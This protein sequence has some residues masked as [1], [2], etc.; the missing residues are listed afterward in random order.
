MVN[1][2]QQERQQLLLQLASSRDVSN[3]AAALEALLPRSTVEDEY[4]KEQ[5]EWVQLRAVEPLLAAD[6][7]LLG[8]LISPVMLVLQHKQHAASQHV[9]QHQHHN[10]QHQQDG[11]HDDPR[12]QQQEQ[13]QEQH[14]SGAAA[15]PGDMTA[16]QDAAANLLESIASQAYRSHDAAMVQ[17]LQ[18]QLQPHAKWLLRA[19]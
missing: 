18:E 5:A 13:Q 6:E 19:A 16:A 2:T 9:Q 7:Q 15:Y 1:L 12:Q 4:D 10:K 14:S 11:E 17:Q 8:Q 3:A